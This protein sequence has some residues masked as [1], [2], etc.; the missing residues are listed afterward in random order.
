MGKATE[1]ISKIRESFNEIT[2]HKFTD[3]ELDAEIKSILGSLTEE[4]I[5]SEVLEEIEGIVSEAVS[6]FPKAKQIKSMQIILKKVIK[7]IEPLRKKSQEYSDLIAKNTRGKGPGA[8]ND[9]E[10]P[11]ARKVRLRK[12]K[13]WREAKAK[14]QAEID[15]QGALATR[16]RAQLDK[17]NA[18]RKEYNKKRKQ[19]A[20]KK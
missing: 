2:F 17:L 11:N 16:A 6:T 3:A 18:E 20:K 5:D 1:L 4:E 9:K 19:D 15:K 14:L 8:K 13:G 12:M 7:A 10:S